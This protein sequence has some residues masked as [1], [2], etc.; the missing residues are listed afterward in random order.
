MKKLRDIESIAIPEP[1]D[2]AVF[3]DEINRLEKE[4]DEVKDQIK[5]IDE[6]SNDLRENFERAKEEFERLENEKK[7]IIKEANEAK[8]E[9]ETSRQE[10]TKSEDAVKY[11]KGLYNDILQKEVQ[12]NEKIKTE[13]ISLKVYG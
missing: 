2:I 8:T 1:L 11:Y 4:I 13:K 9:Y 5:R 10:L 6:G 3:E 12:I 7:D